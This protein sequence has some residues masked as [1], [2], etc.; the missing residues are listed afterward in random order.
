MMVGVT[1]V[2]HLTPGFV[3]APAQ[4][5]DLWW[6]QSRLLNPQ[7]RGKLDDVAREGVGDKGGGVGVGREVHPGTV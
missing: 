6:T 4:V 3:A 5:W 1:G 2:F 7:L